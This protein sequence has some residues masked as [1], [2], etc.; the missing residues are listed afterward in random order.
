GGPRRNSGAEDGPEQH[1]GGQPRGSGQRRVRLGSISLGIRGNGGLD[2]LLAHRL[3]AARIGS[4]LTDRFAPLLVA[5]GLDAPQ[6]IGPALGRLGLLLLAP[7][8]VVPVDGARVFVPQRLPAA[9]EIGLLAERVVDQLVPFRRPLH[10]DRDR[11]SDRRCG[12]TEPAQ[13]WL[14]FA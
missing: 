3:A 9:E 4:R 10:I 1:A 14:K 12:G 13:Y 6:G 2:E 7:G 11:G 5:P 8:C